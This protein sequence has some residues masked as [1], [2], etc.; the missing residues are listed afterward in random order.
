MR[1]PGSTLDDFQG[2]HQPL[3]ERA[4]IE[5]AIADINKR[6]NGAGFNFQ[7]DMPGE[8]SGI[9]L[10]YEDVPDD[11]I[12]V[13]SSFDFSYYYDLEIVFHDALKHDLPEDNPW[14][15]H[16][17]KDQ[18]VLHS[19][20]E[21]AAYMTEAGIRPD[22]NCYLFGFNR[23]TH[24]DVIYKVLAKGFSY[25]FGT[26]YYYNRRA[27]TWLGKDERVAWWVHW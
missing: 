20:A 8:T 14:W 15:D 1:S 25:H 7:W 9:L 5:A 18:I 10:S 2:R 22:P 19:E 17:E 21:T 23:G 27:E 16:W 11:T 6:I 13:I 3:T 26:V 4:S 12:I 24:S